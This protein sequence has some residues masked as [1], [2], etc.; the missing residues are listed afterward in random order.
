M[1]REQYAIM[2][3]REERH[4]WYAGMRRVALAVLEHALVGQTDLRILDA[5]CG[6]GGTTIELQR[7]GRVVG[8][9]V[10]WEAW[11]ARRSNGC[12]LATPVLTSRPALK[13][14]TTWGWL[15][16]CRH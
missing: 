12:P 10:A 8:V 15:T 3:R 16:I 11:R 13:S 4:W 1:E 6:T 2:A 7:F 9:D 5:G 14:S